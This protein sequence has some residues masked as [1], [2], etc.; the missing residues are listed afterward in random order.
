L[1]EAGSQPL[2]GTGFSI[3][4]EEVGVVFQ[5]RMQLIPGVE[6]LRSVEWPNAEAVLAAAKE[7]FAAAMAQ[8]ARLANPQLQAM[9]GLA[10]LIGGRR[11]LQSYPAGGQVGRGF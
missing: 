2:H 6:V 8:H 9:H 5:D 11:H 7:E 1:R 4:V 3:R 10:G